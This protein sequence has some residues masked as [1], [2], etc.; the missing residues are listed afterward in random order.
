MTG[1]QWRKTGADQTLEIVQFY[2]LPPSCQNE[3]SI[4][5]DALEASPE[6]DIHLFVVAVRNMA[7]HW[8]SVAHINLGFSVWRSCS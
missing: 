2:K 3:K 4:M 8:W 6:A 7:V 5:P 1:G